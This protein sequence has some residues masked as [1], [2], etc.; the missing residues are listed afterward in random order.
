MGDNILNK[1][2]YICY[3]VNRLINTA[4]GRHKPDDRDSY[5]NKRIELPGELLSQLFKQYYKK[6]INDISRFFKNKNNDDINPINVISQIKPNTIEQGIKTG[7]L[8]GIWGSSK[9]KKGVAQALQRYTYLQTISYLRRI[10]APAVDASTT[11][12]TSIR[13]VHNVQYGYICG[14]ET[15]EG[16]KIGLIK[17]LA[18][19]A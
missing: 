2:I 1:A 17:N 19:S 6:M 7:L 13:H 9:S 12:V 18:L 3:M 4:I 10:I 15:P 11:K 14:V 16:G 5:V 8:T